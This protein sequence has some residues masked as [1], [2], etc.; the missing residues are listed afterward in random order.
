MFLQELEKV[1]VLVVLTEALWEQWSKEI[2]FPN[3]IHT[4]LK[5]N[6]VAARRAACANTTKRTQERQDR[7]E[8][9]K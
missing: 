9:G 1:T 6:L 8:T 3:H 7:N 5:I 2:T 4:V